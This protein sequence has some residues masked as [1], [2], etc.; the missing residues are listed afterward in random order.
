[1]PLYLSEVVPK[2]HRGSFV[3]VYQLMIISGIVLSY[4]IDWGTS[5]ISGSA[6]W[7]IPVVRTCTHAH[8]C[9]AQRLT[10]LGLIVKF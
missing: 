2:Q 9:C 7:R 6:S 10:M 1:M 5:T 4:G 8:C 3:S